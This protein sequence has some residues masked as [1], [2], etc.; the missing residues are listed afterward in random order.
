MAAALNTPNKMNTNGPNPIVGQPPQMG[1]LTAPEPQTITMPG[2]GNKYQAG[3][4][5]TL[6]P[7][8][9][10]SP[11]T[12]AGPTKGMGPPTAADVYKGYD[13]D[14]VT[15]AKARYPG[16]VAQ[17]IDMLE[18][19]KNQ[20]AERQNRIDVWSQ[21]GQNQQAVA[22]LRVEHMDAATK[23]R[24]ALGF[25][26]IANQSKNEAVRAAASLVATEMRNVPL[27]QPLS[28]QAQQAATQ[29]I[30][31]GLV[32]PGLMPQQAPQAQQPQQSQTKQG[33]GPLPMPTSKSQ[34]VAG[35]SYQTGRG[36]ATWDGNQFTTGQ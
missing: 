33:A 13:P 11:G 17:Q 15:A 1:G 21:R 35:Q 30:A 36:V 27:G 9:M 28:P 5:G 4:G 10:G 16:N 19:Q 31:D 32:P 24:T 18:N 3:P 8:V 20:A 22:Q 34:L 26:Q 25:A 12:F 29:M 7:E 14:D 23:A 2:S 6:K